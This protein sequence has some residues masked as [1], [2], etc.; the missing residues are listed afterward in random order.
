MTDSEKANQALRDFDAET[1][2]YCVA[3]GEQRLALVQAYHRAKD[4]DLAAAWQAAPAADVIEAKPKG[5]KDA[6]SDSKA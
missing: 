2:A 1:N 3:R 4:A 5:K 6:V